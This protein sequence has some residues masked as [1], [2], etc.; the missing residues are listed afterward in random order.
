[1]QSLSLVSVLVI[2]PAT[3]E[4]YSDFRPFRPG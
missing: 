3:D 1:M 4:I 2:N